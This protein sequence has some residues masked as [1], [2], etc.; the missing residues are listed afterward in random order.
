MGSMGNVGQNKRTLSS[1]RS[2]LYYSN[3]VQSVGKS[4]HL[5]RD[6]IRRWRIIL[7]VPYQEYLL[8]K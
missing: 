2:F 7:E 6:E 5:I 4:L 1:E 8:S 3:L